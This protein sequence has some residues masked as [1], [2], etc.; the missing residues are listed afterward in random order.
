MGLLYLSCHSSLRHYHCLL[1]LAQIQKANVTGRGP[2][3][4]TP[5]GESYCELPGRR[6]AL[7]AEPESS[8]A[9]LCWAAS[10]GRAD[11]IRSM[12]HRIDAQPITSQLGKGTPLLWAIRNGYED[13]TEV[14][15]EKSTD[16]NAIDEEGATAL[17]W[18]ARHGMSKIAKKLTVKGADMHIKDKNGED[19]QTWARTGKDKTLRRIQ[20]AS[21]TI[22]SDGDVKPDSEPLGEIFRATAA[23]DLD[24]IKLLHS[25]GTSLE[26]RDSAGRTVIFHSVAEKQMGALRLLL[27][28]GATAFAI[29]KMGFTPLH[30]A[31]QSCN[32]EATQLLIDHGSNVS[33]LSNSRTTPLLL[34]DSA[35][36]APIL[37]ALV[38]QG[39]DVNARDSEGS[40]ITHVI[41]GSSTRETDSLFAFLISHNATLDGKD[42]NGNSPAHIAARVGNE[43]MIRFLK[44]KNIDL[45][46]CQNKEGLTPLMLAVKEDRTAMV[47]SMLQMG[48]WTLLHSID[49]RKFGS[50]LIQ[51]KRLGICLAITKRPKVSHC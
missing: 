28:L 37:E 30:L 44:S 47:G 20:Q 39:A 29:D 22:G 40:S 1:R 25:N 19:A 32:I 5:F 17:H 51:G 41:A 21:T 16:L 12:A 46:A 7:A 2:R 18:A 43:G 26:D 23:G 3:N 49:V 34:V 10:A 14:L 11:I 38:R 4:P 24:A 42:N 45:E 35:D 27:E 31:A 36:G 50:C 13:I 6:R 48:R 9:I 33:A 15:I 8:E